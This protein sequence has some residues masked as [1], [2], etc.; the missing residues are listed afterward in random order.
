VKNLRHVKEELLQK[1]SLNFQFQYFM[2]NGGSDVYFMF[3]AKTGTS[4]DKVIQLYQDLKRDL[5]IACRGNLANLQ[6]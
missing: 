4:E 3:V 2:M 1:T 5:T 6:D